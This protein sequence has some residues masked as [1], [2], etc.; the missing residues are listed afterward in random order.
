MIKALIFDF[1]GLILETEGPVYQSWQEIYK[2]YGAELP[3]EIW[4]NIIGTA[5]YDY[6]PI[7]ELEKI[8]GKEL[9]R[10]EIQQKRNRIELEL[11]TQLSPLPGVR[12]A[13]ENAKNMGLKL[14]VASSSTREWV[15]G[16]LKR[17]ELLR[18]FDCIK[19]SDDVRNTKP[20]PEL[21]LQCLAG[22]A[23]SPD[24][25][26]VFEDSPH[27][28]SAATQAGIVCVAVPN[29]LTKQLDTNHADLRL[30]SLAEIPLKDLLQRIE[31]KRHSE[32]HP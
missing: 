20:D 24:E 21:F 18:Y 11:V 15:V 25:A 1:D 32:H 4:S 16:H 5:N 22:L 6:S 12:E 9:P 27:G 14:G 3:F 26:V 23:V 2:E 10:E 17:L 31:A 13:I 29:P 8:V 19:T 28:I 30:D 7:E